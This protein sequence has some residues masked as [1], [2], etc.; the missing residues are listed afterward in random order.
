MSRNSAA[1]SAT[2]LEADNGAR[3]LHRRLAGSFAENA[4][5]TLAGESKWRGVA[6]RRGFKLAVGLAVVLGL[7]WSPLKALLV[8]TSV[9]AVVNARLA[10]IRSPIEGYVE[11]TPPATSQWRG[12]A[13]APAFVIANPDADRTPLATARREAADNDDRI[14]INASE[15]RAVESALAGLVTQVEQF[16]DSRRE[17]IGLRL[18]GLTDEADA[19]SAYAEQAEAQWQR[20]RKL[21]ASG[22]TPVAQEEKAKV[23]AR[24]G[25]LAARAAKYKAAEAEVEGKALAKGAFVG[26]AYNDTPN[27]EQAVRELRLRLAT[28]QAQASALARSRARLA[29]E[30]EREAT[31]YARRSRASLALPASGR[32]F[33]ILVTRGERVAKSQ[34]LMRVLDCETAIV[35]ANVE[36][37]VYNRL[38]VGAKARFKPSDGSAAIL[39][40]VVNLTGANAAPGVLAISPASLRKSP[41]YVSIALPQG[42]LDCAVGRTGTVTFPRD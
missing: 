11:E 12:K 37:T 26:D 2:S 9:E 30:L 38:R 34:D 1:T 4:E 42:T 7:G 22:V 25:A 18:A 6:A 24:A 14:E 33:E 10:T 36:E 27:S 21:R 29:A 13:A 40:D 41:F 32:I 15:Q 8:P 19:A 3:A 17:S 39:G 16:R 35:S 20:A 5:Q 23:Q 28:L 31:D